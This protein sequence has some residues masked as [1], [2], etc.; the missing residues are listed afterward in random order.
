MDK[1]KMSKEELEKQ[2]KIYLD[3]RNICIVRCAH[4]WEWIDESALR[5]LPLREELVFRLAVRE[6]IDR[7]LEAIKH[8]TNLIQ[9]GRK[10]LAL[11]A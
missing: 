2:I 9:E 3:H 5:K 10:Q 8:S 11:L 4:L 7:F 6:E 1:G